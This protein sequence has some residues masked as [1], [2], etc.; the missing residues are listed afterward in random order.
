[1]KKIGLLLLISCVLFSCKSKS[2]VITEKSKSKPKTYTYTTKKPPKH[3]PTTPKPSPTVVT[4][5]SEGSSKDAD[6]V[7]RKALSYKGTRYKY[8]GTSKSGMD[9]S[10]LMLTSFKTININ[11]PRTSIDQSR[12][13]IA[14]SNSKIKKGDLLFFKTSRKNRINHVGLVV[15]AKGR[16]IKFIHS[17]TSRGVMISSLKEGYWSNAYVKARRV[18]TDKISSNEPT[19]NSSSSTT[20]HYTVKKGDT[21]YGIARKYSGV[22]ANDIISY[23]NLK[24]TNLRPGMVLKIPTI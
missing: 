17:S 9:C 18:L 24:S 21:L 5:S 13:G 1:M 10:G 2:K 14:I 4:S 23:N 20:K 3:N 8:G 16:D 11:L 19:N 6:K 15:S 7:V 22:S 12:K